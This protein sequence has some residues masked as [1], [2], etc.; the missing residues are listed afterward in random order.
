M[1]VNSFFSP[2]DYFWSWPTLAYLL[3]GFLSSTSFLGVPGCMCL[4]SDN[5]LSDKFSF[6]KPPFGPGL[7]NS[8]WPYRDPEGI[9][10]LKLNCSL[11]LEPD[12]DQGSLLYTSLMSQDID[13][14]SF[15]FCSNSVLI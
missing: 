12:L 6:L 3:R 4:I 11:F 9:G 14:N 8:L 13:S 1:N 2:D 7:L 15:F 5:D 10:L